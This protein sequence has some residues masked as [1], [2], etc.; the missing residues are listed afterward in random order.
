MCGVAVTV[1]AVMTNILTACGTEKEGQAVETS[2]SEEPVTL[3]WYVNYS[4]FATPWGENAVSKKITEETGVNI[5]FI[6]PI[7][8]ETEKLNALIASDTLPDFI[9]LGY[10][11]PQ[12]N[13]MIEKDMVYALNELADDYDAYFWQVTDADVV[14]WYTLDDGNIYGYPCSTMTPKQLEEQDDITS[15]ITFLSVFMA[16]IILNKSFNTFL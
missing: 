12:V 13:E 10:W 6:T 3:D 11:E 16:F 8:N 7:G 15:N 4:W 9:T 2:A 5:N 14:N 1:A